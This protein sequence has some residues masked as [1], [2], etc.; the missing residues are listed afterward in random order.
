MADI[1]RIR[2]APGEPWTEIPVIQGPQGERGN[3]WMFGSPDPNTVDNWESKYGVKLGDCYLQT[4]TGN[5]YIYRGDDTWEFKV[6]LKGQDGINGTKGD[7]GMSWVVGNPEPNDVEDWST[8]GTVIT[9][10]LYLQ[11][12][13]G[14]VWQ[15]QEDGSWVYQTSLIGPQGTPGES[16]PKGD[17]GDTYTITAAD[18]D[19]IADVV[20]TK[21]PSAEGVSY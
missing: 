11:R 4:T 7:R 14:K 1:L 17:P 9:G 21:L 18:Y 5:A 19:A 6:C 13:T 8:Y 10:D 15:L 3:N 16:G 12:G 20:L 2:S